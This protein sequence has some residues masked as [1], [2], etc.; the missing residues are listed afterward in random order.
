MNPKFAIGDRLVQSGGVAVRVL[1]LYGS[2]FGEPCYWVSDGVSNWVCTESLL[3]KEV[4]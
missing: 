2:P 4:A 3:E 1:S